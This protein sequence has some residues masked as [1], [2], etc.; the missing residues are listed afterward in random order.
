MCL[1]R[2]SLPF[3]RK[4]GQEHEEVQ[5]TLTTKRVLPDVILVILHYLLKELWYLCFLNFPA[6]ALTVSM[7]FSSMCLSFFFLFGGLQ[8][9]F[10]FVRRFFLTSGDVVLFPK[11]KRS[12]PISCANRIYFSSLALER[13]PWHGPSP[14]GKEP[15]ARSEI[16]KVSYLVY[17]TDTL[18]LIQRRSSLYVSIQHK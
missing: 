12:L 8:S 14:L 9:S 16:Q 13:L 5:Q 1:Q 15:V 2:T 6:W 18:R 10:T 3:F 4:S 17:Q 7:R 11:S